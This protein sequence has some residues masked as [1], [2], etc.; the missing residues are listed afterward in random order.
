METPTATWLTPAAV[1]TDDGD[2]CPVTHIQE[3]APEDREQY[4]SP[5]RPR[6]R[7]H[8]TTTFASI[9]LKQG[10]GEST[11]QR[12][13]TRVIKCYFNNNLMIFFIRLSVG[14]VIYALF[15]CFAAP[16]SAGPSATMRFMEHLHAGGSAN[17][18]DGGEAKLY[19]GSFFACV[20]C[21]VLLL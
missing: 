5:P 11:I 8:N 2:D 16:A 21:L 6:S 14:A 12:Q 18:P 7:T 19:G 10:Q 9:S 15:T 13:H 1:P 17:A 3:G 20:L 4:P